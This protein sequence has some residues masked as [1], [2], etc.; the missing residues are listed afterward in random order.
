MCECVY[1]SLFIYIH[2]QMKTS[3]HAYIQTFLHTHIHTYIQKY[4]SIYFDFPDVPK[5]IKTKKSWFPTTIFFE[6]W[7]NFLVMIT[8][9]GAEKSNSHSRR[10]L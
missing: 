2:T 9:K 4:T 5:I 8:S 10:T 1:V 7:A 3:S 6:A